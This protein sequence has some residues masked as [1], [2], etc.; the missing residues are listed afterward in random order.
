[1]ARARATIW[2]GRLAFECP[3]C[4]CIHMVTVE[5]YHRWNWNGSIEKP[6]LRPALRFYARGLLRCHSLVTDGAIQFLADCTHPLAGKTIDLQE[7]E[8]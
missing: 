5:G 3:G 8:P 4:R 7:V 6:T 1:M 2:Q